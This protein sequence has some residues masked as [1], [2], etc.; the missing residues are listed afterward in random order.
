MLDAAPDPDAATGSGDRS[1]P[2]TA[3][4][5]R[6]VAIVA[7]TIAVVAAV[8]TPF[9]P[10]STTA[11]T[12][13]WPQ[14][15]NLNAKD[16]SIVA[17]LIAQTPKS[18]DITIDCAALAT[19]P[20]TATVLS[21]MA[22]GAQRAANKALTVS[23]SA[24]NVTVLFRSR[25]AAV[26]SRADIAA[27]RCDVL[28]IF[29]TVGAT[30][31]EFVGLAPATLLDPDAR[32][33]VDGLYT[34]LTTAQ[35]AAAGTGIR[36]H[37]AID[38]RYESHASPIKLLAMVLAV[39]ATVI[40]LFALW[41]L[42]RIY[43][44][45]G[46]LRLR[47]GSWASRLRPK[48]SDLAVGGTLAVWT[49]IGAGA[50]DD[51]YILTMAR[52][53]GDAGYLSNYYRYFGITEAPFDWYYSFLSLWAQV[54]PTIIWMHLPQFVAGVA[55]WLLLSRVVLP[56]LGTSVSQNAWARW[57][58]GAVF[59]AF[60]LPFCSG[61]RGEAIIVLG[62]L[63][64]WWAAEVAITRQRLLPA[65]LAATAAAFTLA[66]APQGI[67]GIA[68]LLV[69]ARPLLRILTARR[70]ES[71]L[72]ALLAPIAAAGTLVT[73]VVFRDQTLMG[74]LEAMKLRY[75]T[76]PIVPWHQEFLRYYFLSVGT[77]D[78][79][80]ARRIPVLL[81][82]VA[83]FLVA[84]VLLRRGEIKGVATSPTWRLIG[85][86][87]VSLLLLF[88]TPVKWTIQFGVLTALGAALAGVATVA[89]AQSSARS[90]RNL[91][92]LTAGLL[93]ALAAASAGTNAW[94]YG[95]NFGIPWFDIAPVVAGF[96]VSSILLTLAVI[97]VAA[98]LWLHL[99]SDYVTNKGLAHH[100]DGAPDS[101]ADRRRLA[102]ASTPLL[103][104]ATLM[105]VA[106]VVA[107]GRAAVVRGP[108]M[109]AASTNID[110]V[111]GQPCAMADQV[112]VESD[113]NSNVLTP[114]N[115]E[116][117]T[118]A[119]TGTKSVGFSPDG[120]PD[121]LTPENRSARAG[122]MH[123]GGSTSKPFAVIGGLGAGT[124]G[125]RGPET[126]N[127]SHALL[128][129]GLDPTTTPVVGSFGHNAN[130]YLTTGWYR[131]P[132]RD[133]SPLLVVATAGAVST[134]D[135]D[136]N[137]TFGQK[138]VFQFGTTGRDGDFAQVG[139]DV[140]PIDPG[141]VIANRPWR[142]L[143]V[144]MSAVPA[145]ADVMRLALA[146]T[147]LGPMQF[148]AIT[149][150][151]AP[152][153][154][155]LQDVVGSHDPVLIDFPVAAWFPCQRP[156]AIRHGVAE[157][158]AWRILPDYVTANSQ[159]KTWMAAKSGGLL[160]I[161]EATTTQVTVPTYLN[162]DWRRAWGSL[163]KQ[164]PLSPDAA[165]ARVQTQSIRTSGLTRGG[166]NRVEPTE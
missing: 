58:T 5:A 68:V 1:S 51:G 60:W 100:A 113:P 140:I 44:Y 94:P 88:G 36:A 37:V 47:S 77:P 41:C 146:D 7:G 70:H 108:A 61:L 125:G 9:L 92:A 114:A 133:A 158:P 96:E 90:L 159:S 137:P 127:G 126:V 141:P 4:T 142:N 165:T 112:L 156:L 10:V 122:Q 18:L 34:S 128:P 97:A 151:R 81:M 21:T 2:L 14:G 27:G 20:E 78:G 24:S 136:G 26:A 59:L 23:A 123:V 31:A 54:S 42:D 35:V 116:T 104:I 154:Q 63:L 118:A 155:T 148:L 103:V 124:T 45:T 98:T 48:L 139:S 150:P 149:P 109:T 161:P 160:A 162:D 76:G 102:M 38:N 57:T 25:L 62:S 145:N 28:H 73:V 166:A 84:A 117:A 64:T 132:A 69:A 6:L 135:D 80:L 33:Q 32:P 66:L 138:M 115:G 105:V 46:G 134:I 95:Y 157:V 121:D 29:S 99:R 111:R 65:A 119:L 30:G 50:P 49:V 144:P 164:T 8:L 110:A 52:T 53:A 153:L 131:L 82:F 39:L 55:S 89:I 75:Q 85:A 11:A 40:A 19:F 101:P 130:A 129:F 120:I 163:E 107:F 93:F 71:G 79:A 106:T 86:F 43:G 152:K 13:T 87:G 16:A 3:R 67:V 147:N 143:R 83:A 72:V 22:P 56:H 17:P 15:Q 91:A 12:I 74:V